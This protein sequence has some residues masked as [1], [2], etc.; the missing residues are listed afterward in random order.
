MENVHDRTGVE[1]YFAAVCAEHTAYNKPVIYYTSERVKSF[2]EMITNASL[3]ENGIR[4][5]AYCIGGVDGTPQ[6]MT[7]TISS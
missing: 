3:S 5:E 2:I 4:M 1:I 6:N 7:I